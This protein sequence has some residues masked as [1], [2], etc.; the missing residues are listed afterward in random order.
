[1]TITLPA[2]PLRDRSLPLVRLVRAQEG[3]GYADVEHPDGGP[4]HVPL[5]W[6]DRAAPTSVPQSE[7]REVRLSAAGLLQMAA[8]VRAALA[9]KHAEPDD[10]ADRRFQRP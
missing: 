8:A 7:G 3:D 1:V 10:P 9:A 6:T 2:H 4:F 5:G